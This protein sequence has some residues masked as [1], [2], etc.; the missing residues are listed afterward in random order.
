MGYLDRLKEI[1]S[2]QTPT[3]G[4]AKTVK[5]A[6]GGYDSRASGHI[7]KMGTAS[8]SPTPMTA[9][10]ET[11]IRAW[12]AYIQETDQDTL[13]EV[14]DQCRTDAGAREYFIGRAGEVPR[15]ADQGV[16]A[17]SLSTQKTVEYQPPFIDPRTVEGKS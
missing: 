15:P 13:S 17:S 16:N 11:A 8:N 5:R 2:A 12:L 4:T 6:F 14:L 1:I 9:D 7:Q 3:Q 10:E